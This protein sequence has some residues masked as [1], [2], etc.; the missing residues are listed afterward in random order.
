MCVQLSISGSKPMCP[1]PASSRFF[2]F[3]AVY[4]DQRAV[5]VVTIMTN[6]SLIFLVMSILCKKRKPGLID[7][8]HPGHSKTRL[9]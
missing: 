7:S 3:A 9:D 5:A 6:Y 4:R 8:H 1:I 2:I